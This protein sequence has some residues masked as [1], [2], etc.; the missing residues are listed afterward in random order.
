MVGALLKCDHGREYVDAQ[1]KNGDTAL[2]VASRS[3]YKKVV[4]ELLSRKANKN[5]TNL[6]SKINVAIFMKRL[7]YIAL[8]DLIQLLVFSMMITGR[9][10]TSSSCT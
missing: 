3:G 5:I 6:V 7:K 8:S 4:Q 10:D 2:H 9:K 1:D